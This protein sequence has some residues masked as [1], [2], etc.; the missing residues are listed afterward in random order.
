MFQYFANMFSIELL[1][2]CT[3]LRADILANLLYSFN[4]ILADANAVNCG[5]IHGL[6]IAFRWFDWFGQGDLEAE[7]QT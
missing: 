4:A 2:F 6:F 7:L 1:K 5:H 3:H